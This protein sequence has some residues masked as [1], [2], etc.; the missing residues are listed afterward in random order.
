MTKQTE[1][2]AADVV[3]A[4]GLLSGLLEQKKA[5]RSD[6]ELLL[7]K[8]IQ[9]EPEQTMGKK[10]IRRAIEAVKSGEF[11]VVHSYYISSTHPDFRAT[12]SKACGCAI[13]ALYYAGVQ[14]EVV[15]QKSYVSQNEIHAALKPHIL[16][17]LLGS[18]ENVYELSGSSGHTPERMIE[19][20]SELLEM[21]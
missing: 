11:A 12:L 4:S 13:A 2:A 17:F 7:D 6:F 10:L 5:Q 1:Q 9:P 16:P 8:P 21:V 20:L 18:L 14:L 3:D 19:C 15:E